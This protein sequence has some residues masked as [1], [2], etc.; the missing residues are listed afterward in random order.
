MVNE[1]KFLFAQGDTMAFKLKQMELRKET[2]KWKEMYK[3]KM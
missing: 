2:I 3:K 1:I